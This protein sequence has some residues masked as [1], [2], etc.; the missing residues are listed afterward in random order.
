MTE[1]KAIA[2]TDVLAED[3]AAIRFWFRELQR[4]VQAVDFVSARHLFRNDFIA[5]GTFSD[6]VERQ[7]EIEQKQW[8]NVWPTID[9]FVW[10]DDIRALVSPD[11]LFAVGLGVFDSTGY[12][13]DGTTFPRA[14][15]ATVSFVRK[16]T[17]EKFVANHTHMSLFRGTPDISNGNKPSLS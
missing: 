7:P 5:F 17:E 4:H 15:R 14:G 6:F 13:S 3:E 2:G 9:D 1:L 10:R 8:R 16:S 11:R 12:H